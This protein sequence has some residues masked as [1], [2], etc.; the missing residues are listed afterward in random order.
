MSLVAFRDEMGA[1]SRPEVE[2]EEGVKRGPVGLGLDERCRQRRPHRALVLKL[3]VLEGAQRVDVVAYGY[4][5]SRLP[6]RARELEDAI[7]TP[8]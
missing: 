3:H 2:V 8:E 1:S 5:H 7:E 6:E 4:R